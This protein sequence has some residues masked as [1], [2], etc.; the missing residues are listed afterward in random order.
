MKI[1]DSLNLVLPVREDELYVYHTPISKEVFEINYKAL[2]AVKG[3]L[4]SK[5]TAYQMLSGPSIAALALK[6]EIRKSFADQMDASGA[7]RVIGAFF[8]ELRRLSM[9]L[10]AGANGYEMKPVDVAIKSGALDAEDWEEVESS[11][12]F[13]TC[14][15]WLTKRAQRAALANAAASLLQGFVT[16]LSVSELADSLPK[17]TNAEASE[18]PVKVASSVPV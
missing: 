6:D 9:V 16:S 10:V 15:Y 11:L 7:D 2:A 5:G 18:K 14:H 4:A 1:D 3:E 13:F 12:V 8:A 17:L